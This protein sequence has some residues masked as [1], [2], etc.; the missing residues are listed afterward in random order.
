[1]TGGRGGAP[2]LD[3]VRAVT[4]VAFDEAGERALRAALE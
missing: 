2:A 3:V 1:M 4:F